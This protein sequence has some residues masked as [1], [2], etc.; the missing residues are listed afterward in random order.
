M[1]TNMEIWAEIRRRE[2]TGEYEIHWDTLKKILEHVEPPGYRRA[3][4]PAQPKIGP[5]VDRIHEI[6]KGDQQVSRKQRHTA[7]RIFVRL[8]DEFGHEGTPRCANEPC[9]RQLWTRETP[10]Y[11]S[12]SVVESLDTRNAVCR[13]R[14]TD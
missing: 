13:V 2:L 9:R 7:K 12:R 8:R 10:F 1:Y 3:K 4:P 14:H 6:L 11:T 5:F